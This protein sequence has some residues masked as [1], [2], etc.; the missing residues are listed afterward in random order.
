MRITR[1][2]VYSETLEQWINWGAGLLSVVEVI[3]ISTINY[4][5]TPAI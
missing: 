3:P 4:P 2:L 5:A 1:A